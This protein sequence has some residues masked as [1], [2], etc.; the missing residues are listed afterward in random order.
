MQDAYIDTHV[1]IFDRH[2]PLLETKWNPGGEEATMEQVM[3]EFQTHGISHGV[4]STS[5]IYGLHHDY[6]R[7]AMAR[8]P[9]LRATVNVP[10]EI[11]AG[12]LAQLG[13]Q[14]FLGIRLLWR[15]LDQVPDLRSPDYQRLLRL[16]A[17]QNWHVHLTDKAG[18]IGETITLLEQAGVRVVLDH[19]GMVDS[20]AGAA[21]PA[22]QAIL[23]AIDR[24]RTWVKLSGGFR[25][26]QPGCATAQ[27]KA[28]LAA[29]G[30]GRVMWG[31]DW[32][33]VG[34]L[35]KV[36]YTQTVACLQDWASDA[37]MRQ[38]VG[39]QTALEFY[40]SET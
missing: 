35:G 11:D 32:P 19:L 1:H 33:F 40:F 23:R 7:Q 39:R 22:F 10:L 3:A 15:P 12:G 4:I 31:S 27:A 18:R 16:C 9:Q 20:P 26:A 17:D 5:S 38:A 21:D 36:H 2:T 37:A 34:H 30:W 13:A 6:F 8:F 24:G 14:G 29:G 25:F 28:L